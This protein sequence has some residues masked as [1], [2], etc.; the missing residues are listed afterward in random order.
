MIC[1]R[2]IFSTSMNSFYNNILLYTDNALDNSG[3]IKSFYKSCQKSHIKT[4]FKNTW[5]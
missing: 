5:S 1:L 3:F 4:V 2:T